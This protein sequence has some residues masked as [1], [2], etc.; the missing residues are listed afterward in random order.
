MHIDQ[1]LSSGRDKRFEAE[2]VVNPPPSP[3]VF[4]KDVIVNFVT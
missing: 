3:R 2:G 4:W 1:H